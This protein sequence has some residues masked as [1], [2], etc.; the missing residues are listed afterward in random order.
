MELLVIKPGFNGQAQSVCWVSER[1]FYCLLSSF[2]LTHVGLQAAA[3]PLPQHEK[4][5]LETKHNWEAT[6]AEATPNG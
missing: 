3:N 2:I 6:L 5:S 4:A 1:V